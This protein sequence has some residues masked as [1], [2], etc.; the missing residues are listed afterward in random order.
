[1]TSRSPFNRHG[2]PMLTPLLQPLRLP[3]LRPGVRTAALA[4]TLL[5]TAAAD[6]VAAYIGPGAGFALGGSFLFALIGLL[7]ASAAVALWPLR[8]LTRAVRRRGRSRRATVGR[9]VVLGLDGLDPELAARGMAAGELPH[10]ARLRDTG[11]FRP[12]ATTTPP[13]SPVA[14]SGFA[15]GADASRHNIFDFL[16]RDPAT[17]LPILSSTRLTAGRPGVRIGPWTLGGRPPRHELLRRSRTFWRILGEHGVRSAIL[18]VPITFPPEK[19][20]G[21]MLAAMCVPDLRGT[22]GTF[23]HYSSAP[24]PAGETTG[25]T[26]APLHPDGDGAWSGEIIGPDDPRGHGRPPLA[27]PLRLTVDA[28]A[29]LAHLVLDGQRVELIAGRQ[30]PWLRLAFRAGR[31]RVHGLCRVRLTSFTD[32][33][34]F[35]MTPLHVDPEHPALPLSHP[36]HYAIA[37]AKL[38]G[39]YATLGLAE[40]TWALNEGVLDEGAFLE[41]AWAVHAERERQFFHA[42]DRQRDG[43]VAAVF[44]ATDR[45]QHMF[46]RHLDPTHPANRGRSPSP[47]ADAIGDLYRRAD[48]LVG[49][50]VAQLGPRDLLFVISDH[51][52]KPFRRGVNLNAW[53]RAHGWLRVNGDPADGP[54][55]PLG[56]AVEPSEID[57]TRTRAYASGLAGFYLNL[58]GRERDGLV[59]PAEAPALRAEILA[60]LRELR[61]PEQGDEL[62]VSAAWNAHDIY[63]GPYRDNAPDVVVGWRVG[64]RAGWD[65][66]VGRVT[67]AVIEDNT[68]AWSGDHCIDPSLV[69]G[70]FFCTRRPRR[71][72]PALIDLAPTILRLFGI[73]PPG[74]MTGRDIF[75]ETVTA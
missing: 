32:P 43:V 22:Q 49:R 13:I 11:A 74:H 30:S 65:A 71:D 57:W 14:W 41:Q 9:V 60:R 39:P 5:L 46:F 45:I 29:G 55:P 70:V 26:R 24:P 72:D 20:N 12:L 35:Y 37:L 48:D 63:K 36:A 54:P 67:D 15:T 51:G 7:V 33:V 58:A 44:D 34:S 53:F 40:D 10:L 61:D 2:L 18:R 23:T 69:P 4:V 64:W 27:L 8:A 62:V 56:R 68:R 19:F 21:L 75:E 38:H 1:M 6:P 25:G 47:H 66:A 42:L 50:T 31:A 17:H 59:T 16:G 73:D 3:R 52:F 28:A